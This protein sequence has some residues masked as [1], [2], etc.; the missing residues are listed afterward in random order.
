MAGGGPTPANAAS[1]S[2]ISRPVI[3]GAEP[4]TGGRHAATETPAAR[5]SPVLPESIPARDHAILAAALDPIITIDA[6]GIIQSASDSVQR[7]FGWAPQELL[8]RNVTVLMPEPH[9]SA[10]DGYLA[11]YRRTGQTNILG[12]TRELEAVRKNGERFP[13][14][15]S[16]SRVDPPDGGLPLFIGIIRDTSER[17]RIERELRLIKDL[18]LAISSAPDLSAALVETLR[19]VCLATEWDYGEVWLP[20]PAGEELVGVASWMRPGSGLESFAGTM[21]Q[22]RFRRGV[23]LGGRAWATGTPI[24]AGDLSTLTGTDYL[25]PLAAKEAGLHA[26]TAVPVLSDGK[27]IAVLLFFVRTTRRE[28]LHLLELVRAATAPLG[29]LIQRKQAEDQL[30]DYRHRLEEM[31]RERTRE[32]H[33]SQT[34]LRMADRLASI[35]TLAAGLGHDMNNML[36]PVRARLNALRAERENLSARARRNVDAIIKS[37]AYLQ[38]LAD[39]LHFLAMDPDSED[40]TGETT[41]LA[42]WWAQTGPV[43]SKAVPK[44]VKVTAAIP[45]GL[46]E[47]GVAPHAL[48]QAVLNLVVNAGDAIPSEGRKHPGR[49]RVWADVASD[50]PHTRVRVGVTDNG[51]GMSEETR[52]RACEMFFTTK[53][54]GMGTGLGL[55]LVRKVVDRAGGTLA[56]ESR[57]GRGTTV[58]MD[59]PA[60]HPPETHANAAPTAVVSVGDGR[61]AALIRHLLEAAGYAAGPADTPGDADIWL[62]EPGRVPPRQAEEWLQRPAGRGRLILVG[63]PA[64]LDPRHAE[65]WGALDAPT[66]HDPNDFDSVRTAIAHAIGSARRR[67]DP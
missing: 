7:V 9:R 8:G 41:N 15:L 2:P 65:Q 55:S 48:T 59:L 57:L 64:A 22:L 51:R 45:A 1:R 60:A 21:A 47:V 12:R 61:A 18:A 66:I 52:R 40:D 54:R 33:E 50:G 16:V 39:G 38:Q 37:V 46:P 58:I 3:V 29:T 34:K 10:H 49:V 63:D 67:V 19:L 32:L 31:V 25:R 13:I 62:I 44:H 56:I 42:D 35:G 11:N 43:L 4:P 30:N 20:D 24:W 27:P 6:Y 17:K 23:G 36:L 5:Q 14:E 26:G 28:D 53:P